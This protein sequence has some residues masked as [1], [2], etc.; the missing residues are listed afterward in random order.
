MQNILIIDHYKFNTQDIANQLRG[1]GFCVLISDNVSKAIDLI[2]NF[3]WH[4]IPV[5]RKQGR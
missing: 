3:R 1:N 2:V 4:H 5:V